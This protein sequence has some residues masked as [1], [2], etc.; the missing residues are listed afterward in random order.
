MLCMVTR[1][2][3]IGGCGLLWGFFGSEGYTNLSRGVGN[4]QV[5]GCMYSC[6]YFVHCWDGSYGGLW[7]LLWVGIL[8]EME[9]M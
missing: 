3:V 7:P 1:D 5:D 4:G 2:P 8:V 9:H 6:K